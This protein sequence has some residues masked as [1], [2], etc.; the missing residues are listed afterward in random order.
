MKN[1]LRRL[2][3][4]VLSLSLLLGMVSIFTACDKDNP[5]ADSDSDGSASEGT[6]D[7]S[8]PSELDL[9]SFTIVRPSD[10][11]YN[12]Y[13]AAAQ[14]KSRLQNDFNT[15]LKLMSDTAN[16]GDG[17]DPDAHEILVGRTSYPESVEM[18]KSITKHDFTV[19]SVGNKIII[20]GG[21]G[22]TTQQAMEYFVSNCIRKTDNGYTVPTDLDY[23]HRYEYKFAEADITVCS[24]NLRFANSA[25]ENMQ[26]ER[27]PLIV[28]FVDT[29]KPDSLGTQECELFWRG[30]LD[31]TL[32]GYRNAIGTSLST[33]TKNFIWYNVDRLKV[34]DWGVFWLSETPDE[35]SKGFGSRFWISCCWALFEVKET[36]TRYVHMN[37]HFNVD[38]ADIRDKEVEVLLERAQPFLDEGYAVLMTGDFNCGLKSAPVGRIFETGF[39]SAQEEAP[40]TSDMGTYNAFNYD[41][42]YTGPGDFVFTN[43]HATPNECEII[44]K[45]PDANGKMTFLSDHNA[46]FARITLYER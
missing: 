39:V 7:N 43:E 5:D 41:R 35:Q 9:S 3:V 23:T 34:V 32:K 10:D 13:T 11:T 8:V 31:R 16:D 25:S 17:Y 19:R 45:W 14:L 21:R 29:Y 2:L 24:L 26:S 40:I 37:T 27:E 20:M 6:P 46:V 30:R 1:T 15:V 44:D 42:K 36:G 18:A 38:S 28:E 33:I 12:D 22:E 4:L